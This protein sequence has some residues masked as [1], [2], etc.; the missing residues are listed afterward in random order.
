MGTR[1]ELESLAALLARE[2][3]HP[4]VDSTYD[5]RDARS[6]FE[7]LASGDSFGKIV[8]TVAG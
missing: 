6:A 5:L 4:L 3:I 2:G 1:E 8:L 7:R